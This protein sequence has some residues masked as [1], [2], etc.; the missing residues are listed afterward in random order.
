MGTP[1]MWRDFSLSSA[2]LVRIELMVGK[3]ANRI[4]AF[5]F[6]SIRSSGTRRLSQFERWRETR[7]ALNRFAP[8]P[9]MNPIR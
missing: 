5:H 9:K 3:C 2:A 4:S 8:S 1:T 6:H 7:T